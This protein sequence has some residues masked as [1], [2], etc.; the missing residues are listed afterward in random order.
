MCYVAYN[1]P[2]IMNLLNFLE[3]IN[4]VSILVVVYHLIPF[5]DFVRD[6]ETQYN[7]GYSVCA[8]TA[9]NIVINLAFLVSNM[10][11]TFYLRFKDRIKGWFAQRRLRNKQIRA[12]QRDKLTHELKKL[13]KISKRKLDLISVQS[14]DTAE[15][16]MS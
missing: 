15:K 5:S 12:K 2:F 10:S 4:E 7:I 8:F 16:I 13:P 6:R 14:R 9:L 1:Q 3:L 11:M